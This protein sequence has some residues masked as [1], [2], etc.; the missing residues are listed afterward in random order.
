M[1]VGAVRMV[2]VA[3]TLLRS[4]AIFYD[5]M[6]SQT[7]DDQRATPH[8]IYINGRINGMRLYSKADGRK[9]IVSDCI[10]FD[11]GG[12][13]SVGEKVNQD[14]DLMLLVDLRRTKLK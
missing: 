12:I 9:P 4:N 6:P 10:A 11:L 8:R 1:A 13:I 7:N 2:S 3:A 5:L 14:I